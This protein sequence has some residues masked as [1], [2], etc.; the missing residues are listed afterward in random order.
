M[1]RS[2][3]FDQPNSQKKKNK[4]GKI[5]MFCVIV[6]FVSVIMA[7]MYCD[8]MKADTS[9]NQQEIVENTEI[10]EDVTMKPETETAYEELNPTIASMAMAGN[11][12]ADMQNQMIVQ[13]NEYLI[14]V[15]NA[16]ASGYTAP[17]QMSNAYKQLLSDF[18]A[19]YMQKNPQAAPGVIWSEY[20]VWEFN[21]NYDYVA[22]DNSSMKAVWLCY[23]KNDTEKKHPY[24]VCTATYVT[25]TDSFIEPVLSKTEWYPRNTNLSDAVLANGMPGDPTVSADQCGDDTASNGSNDDGEMTKEQQQVR[26]Q[27]Q[28]LID[29]EKAKQNAVTI[30]H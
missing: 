19:K 3:N 21:A 7:Y 2:Y 11:A 18:N 14:T 13:N 1:K 16:E 8:A 5:V 20:G 26:D 17:I 25:E 9:D 6:S 4:D 10:E 23:D 28:L 15:R 30:S 22:E 27:L 29:A 24:A 12:V